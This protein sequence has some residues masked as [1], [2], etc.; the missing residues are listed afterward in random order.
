MT[1][2]DTAAK[3]KVRLGPNYRRLWWASVVSN[4]GDG[5]GMIAYPWLASAVT[6]DPILIGAI[7][8]AQRLPWLVF[9]LPA[10]VLTDR[11]DRR[12]IMV[13]SDVTR[14]FLVVAIAVAVVV[15]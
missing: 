13:V 11:L 10:G 12:K 5:V 3:A 7:V 15:N 9:T 2:T 4:L 14:A 8:A 6:R 1:D